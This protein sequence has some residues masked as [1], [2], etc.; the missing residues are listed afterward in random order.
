MKLKELNPLFKCRFDLLSFYSKTLLP[1]QHDLTTSPL[2]PVDTS[3]IYL[4][5]K[6]A[7]RIDYYLERAKFWQRNWEA[8]L[9]IGRRRFEIR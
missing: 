4:L 5:L 6:V 9:R 3:L 8:V 2:F 7:G 1:W